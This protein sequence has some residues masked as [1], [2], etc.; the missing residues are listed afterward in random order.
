MSKKKRLDSDFSIFLPCTICNNPKAGRGNKL[1]SA[2][3]AL[4]GHK[5]FHHGIIGT[6]KHEKN[7]PIKAGTSIFLRAFADY[8]QTKN[9]KIR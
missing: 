1:S 7:A 2:K 4:G 8:C 9:I 3:S 6:G 5:R